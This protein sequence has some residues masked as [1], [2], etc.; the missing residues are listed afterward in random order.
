MLRIEHISKTFHPGTVNEKKALDDFSL[1]VNDGDFVT[2]IGSNGAGK[3]TLFNS[4]AGNFLVDSGRILLDDENITFTPEYKRSKYI[5]RL[6]QDPLRG[7]APHMTIRE[8]LA[9]AY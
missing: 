4:I 6:F 1:T 5:G 7:T 8:N 3:S 9:L 2:I